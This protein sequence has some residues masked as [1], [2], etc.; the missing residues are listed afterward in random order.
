MQKITITKFVTM[1][2]IKKL[3]TNI[4]FKMYNVVNQYYN[5]PLRQ[6]KIRTNFLER[7][8]YGVSS[9]GVPEQYG[10]LRAVLNALT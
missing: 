10:L 5:K 8:D 9:A 6:K 4:F 1:T 3:L 2:G 7:V